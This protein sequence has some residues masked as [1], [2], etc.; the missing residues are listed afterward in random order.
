MPDIPFL[1]SSNPAYQ[2]IEVTI[3]DPPS[4]IKIKLTGK[5]IPMYDS[6]ELTICWVLEGDR[7]FTVEEMVPNANDT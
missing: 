5:G 7:L 6:G 4:G 1:S 2:Q 3:T